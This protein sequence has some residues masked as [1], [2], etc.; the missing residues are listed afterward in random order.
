MT[1]LIQQEL[2]HADPPACHASPS[3]TD[4]ESVV[5]D[6]NTGRVRRQP[7]NWLLSAGRVAFYFRTAGS[8]KTG[9]VALLHRILHLVSIF[10]F[11]PFSSLPAPA[12]HIRHRAAGFA[13]LTHACSGPGAWAR[14]SPWWPR[15][16]SLPT[17]GWKPPTT[18]GVYIR[19][20]APRP[21]CRHRRGSRLSQIV[22]AGLTDAQGQRSDGVAAYPASEPRP[23]A[24]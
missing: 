4:R 1:S 8:L 14:R 10:A 21:P 13:C 22:L 3:C 17:R 6:R 11:A 19:R 12:H 24:W 7:Q 18:P 23:L 9:S 16:S 2:L 20:E 5:E 15:R